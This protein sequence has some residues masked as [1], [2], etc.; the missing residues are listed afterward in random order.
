VSIDAEGRVTAVEIES[1]TPAMVF[2][3]ATRRAL[4][5]LRYQPA[6]DASGTPI[7]SQRR[8]VLKWTID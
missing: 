1:A 6:L 4:E 8:E 7:A 2:D 3:R 5:T